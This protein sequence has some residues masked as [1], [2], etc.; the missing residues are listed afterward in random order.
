MGTKGPRESDVADFS[1]TPACSINK[2]IPAR[3]AAPASWIWR[4]SFWVMNSGAG[5][6]RIT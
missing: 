4:T 5:P 6:E 3:R 2:S 1:E